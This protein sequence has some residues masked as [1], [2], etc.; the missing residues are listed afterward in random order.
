MYELSQKVFDFIDTLF[1]ENDAVVVKALLIEKCN[2]NLPFYSK[3][4]KSEIDR[5][6]LAVIKMSNGSYAD[7]SSTVE[8]ACID[9]R[10]VL[11]NAV[12]Q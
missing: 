4:P 3:M 9:W 8:V 1:T 10:D 12:G 7:L 5:I 2:D 6:H 11:M